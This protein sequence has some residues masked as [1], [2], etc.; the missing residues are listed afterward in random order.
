MLVIAR[1]LVGAPKVLL[2]DEMSLGLAPIVIQR[3]MRAVRDLA[4]RKGVGIL[5]VE[6]FAHLALAVAD[7]AYVLSRGEVVYDGAP[8][9]LRGDEELLRRLYLGEA[10]S[11]PA[12]VA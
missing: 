5:L 4:D 12:A 2:I 3:L 10:A 9:A 7:R 11:A 8:A 1:A 6:Q